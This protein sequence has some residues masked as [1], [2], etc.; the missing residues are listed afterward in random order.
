MEIG[1]SLHA[2][3]DSLAHVGAEGI[4]LGG[5]VV[6]L[7]AGL[8]R[9]FATVGMLRALTL[10]TLVAAA[11]WTAWDWP[12]DSM[13][14]F[15][16]LIQR[17]AFGSF[18]K[19]VFCV[20]GG[21]TTL[22]SANQQKNPHE[23]FL[24]LLA[25]V[26]GSQ[27]AVMSTHWLIV[28]LALEM[29]AL[30]GYALAGFAFTKSGA[31]G[32]LKYFIMGSAL[33]AVMIYGMSLLYG[34][35][36][37]LN[38]SEAAFT[39]AL[40]RAPTALVLVGGLFVVGGLLLKI[41]SV[42]FHFWAPDTYEAA[43]TPVVAFFSVVPKLAGLAVLVRVSWALYAGGQH[44]VPWQFIIGLAALASMV[45]GNLGALA[46]RMPK[47]LLAYSSIAQSGFMLAAVACLNPESVDALLFYAVVFAVANFAVFIALDRFEKSDGCVDIASFAGLGRHRVGLALIMTV[48]L[49]SL[50]GLPPTG[51]FTA[52][53]FLFTTLW[54]TF[55]GTGQPLY[56]LLFFVGLA[57]TVVSLFFYLRLPYLLFFRTAPQQPAG[58]THGRV[59]WVLAV[60]GVALIALFLKP[61]ALT[62]WINRVTFAW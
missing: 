29:V 59:D 2:N 17:D 21:L 40:L 41:A 27:W 50:T 35:T 53:L 31:E 3:L 51:G 18:F 24:L 42:P 45:V 14:L 15:A 34:A 16:G 8:I 32:S 38:F 9:S 49:L 10:T 1:T 13:P 57:N 44:A 20:A 28:V 47:R 26:F 12:T 33:T 11:G 22:V 4:L 54:G 30:A 61:D 36:G 25:A 56:Q 5:F 19:I 62:G 52:K 46:Q 23:Y 60:V 48:G 6:V 58:A 7:V 55:D 37:S 43:P 39:Q